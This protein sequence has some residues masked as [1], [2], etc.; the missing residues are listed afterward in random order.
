M[1][2]VLLAHTG[3]GGGADS[4][5]FSLL[6]LVGMIIPWIVLGV[7]CWYFWRAKK[8]DEEAERRREWMNAP[9]S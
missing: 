7:V 2:A 5:A 3:T 6:A 9:L 8:R 1:M 4:L